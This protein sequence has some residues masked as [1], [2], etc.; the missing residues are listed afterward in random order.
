MPVG[1]RGAQ[2]AASQHAPA[3]G[4]ERRP[5]PSGAW[6]GDLGTTEW[7]PFVTTDERRRKHAISTLEEQALQRR[8]FN[9]N[10]AM[11]L[12]ASVLL[13]VPDASN[14][15]RTQ[16]RVRVPP[17]MRSSSASLTSAHIVSSLRLR[18]ARNPH[19]PTTFSLN[20]CALAPTEIVSF[21]EHVPVLVCSL[22][23]VH[24]YE[25]LTSL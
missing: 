13:K 6:H 3:V 11:M 7:P 2:L 21:C 24:I 16:V 5:P 20:P 15:P 10:A 23:H 18:N 1:R 19:T 12:A 9:A 25:V 4:S 8:T 17:Q 14:L 22:A